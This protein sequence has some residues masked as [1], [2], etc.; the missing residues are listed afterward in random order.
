MCA[1]RAVL[2]FGFLVLV[3]AGCGS[4]DDS[5][6]VTV[7]PT[8]AADAYATTIPDAS[9][10]QGASATTTAPP[11]VTTTPPLVT[12]L[13]PTTTAPPPA[14]P[15]TVTVAAGDS[16]SQIAK[17]NGMSLDDLAALNSI[18][19]TNQLFVGQ[20]LLLSVDD[21]PNPD[22]E[23]SE[24]TVTVQSGDSLSKIAKRYDTSV[25]SLMADN[26]IDDPNTIFVGQELVVVAAAKTALPAEDPCG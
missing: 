8:T 2:G 25:E 18:C 6:P 19:D 16:L 13:P 4:S 10:A 9:G 20:V 7:T 22:A 5:T 12:T 14:G 21:E 11:T 15:L 3:A 17:D 24:M 1:H 26:D 23:P